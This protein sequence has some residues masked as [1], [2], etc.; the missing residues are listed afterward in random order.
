MNTKA[1]SNPK[2]LETGIVIMGGSGAGFASAVAAGGD[3]AKY[4]AEKE[5]NV[6]Q[7]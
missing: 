5:H 1:A 3:G 7:Q 6:F 4:V 2:S